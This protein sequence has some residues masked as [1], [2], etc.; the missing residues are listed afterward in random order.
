MK[1]NNLFRRALL[2]LMVVT[3]SFSYGEIV[4]LTAMSGSFSWENE[5]YE[6][7][8]NYT[9]KIKTNTYQKITFNYSYNAEP[10]NDYMVFYEID[11][12][13]NESEIAWIES[14]DS[15]SLTT[16]FPTGEA[17]VVIFTNSTIDF[18]DNQEGY[19]GFSFSYQV[20][21]FPYSGT[22]VTNNNASI[23][24]NLGVGIV[25]P[26]TRLHINGPIR[27]DGS[28][29][30]LTVNTTYGNVTM[31]ATSSTQ[32][33]ISTDRSYFL[34]D[35]ALYLS[36]GEFNT[37]A[38]KWQLKTNAITKLT[39]LSSNGNVGIGTTLPSQKLSVLGNMALYPSGTT[40][41]GNYN[42][43]L[44]ITKPT[45]SNQFINLVKGTTAW[46]IGVKGNNYAIGP[47][48]TTDG[49]FT[50]SFVITP[51]GYVGIG[52]TSPDKS[53]TVNGTIHAKEVL[54]DYAIPFPDYVF[55]KHYTLR[56][57]YDVDAFIKDKGHL[58]DI[59]SADDVEGKSINV[60][61][62]QIRLLQKIEELTLYAVDQQ[63]RLDEQQARI[64]AL[65][66][67]LTLERTK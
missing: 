17:K 40:P 56:T 33:T 20:S 65:E 11:E 38:T 34:F 47:G 62:L 21:S 52:T 9:Y 43:S 12:N 61:D 53:L 2:F 8:L 14:D 44:M 55:D 22:Q 63:K 1:S 35:K 48:N 19:T 54:V 25:N 24:G 27:G 58:P 6:N 36:T 28:A 51:G 18:W 31:G 3:S 39:I 7:N 15:G 32:A 4:N 10:G 67:A 13:G 57:L 59:P 23:A 60:A 50:P 29:G 16:N 46:S 45:S 30:S 49:S 66:K 5:N 41:N 26:L 37:T 42:G 64:D